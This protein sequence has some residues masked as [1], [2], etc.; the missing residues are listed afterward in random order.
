MVNGIGVEETKWIQWR[1]AKIT[2]N[3]KNQKST[4][5]VYGMYM[6]HRINGDRR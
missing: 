4:S 5:K 6:A 1:Q 2:C 3:C